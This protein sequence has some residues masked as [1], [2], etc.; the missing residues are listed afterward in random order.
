MPKRSE[1]VAEQLGELRQDLRD[2]W[3][4]LRADPK[5]EARKERAWSIFVGALGAA[6]TMVARRATTKVWAVLSGE[7]PPTPQPAQ[8]PSSRPARPRT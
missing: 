2:L 6:A 3:V 5:K 1:V 7:P 8:T 4:A